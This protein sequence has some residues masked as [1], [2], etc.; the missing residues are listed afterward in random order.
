[1]LKRSVLN[2]AALNIYMWISEYFSCPHNHIIS[3]HIIGEE[4]SK[5]GHV[6]HIYVD[7]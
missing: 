3:G 4:F 1:M 6:K 2:T 5:Y 7:N